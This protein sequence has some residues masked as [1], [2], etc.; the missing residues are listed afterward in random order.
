MEVLKIK[1]LIRG[2]DLLPNNKNYDL[3]KSRQTP[4]LERASQNFV[5]FRCFVAKCCKMR[6]I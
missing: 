4:Q 6:I 2:M 1:V 3:D 5:I